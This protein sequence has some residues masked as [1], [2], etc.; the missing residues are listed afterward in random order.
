MESTAKEH[1]D[2]AQGMLE[3]VVLQS[4]HLDKV[5]RITLREPTRTAPSKPGSAIAP[6]CTAIEGLDNLA[7]TCSK[8]SFALASCACKAS[9]AAAPSRKRDS[10][11]D[12]DPAKLVARSAR[13]TAAN[14]AEAWRACR[15]ACLRKKTGQKSYGQLLHAAVAPSTIVCCCGSNLYP[16]THNTYNITKQKE[17]CD[18]FTKD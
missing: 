16:M 12:S 17:A 1:G 9:A 2:C 4:T 13:P 7:R 8:A 18:Q 14:S 15:S 11:S 3:L 6:S 5:T 10:A